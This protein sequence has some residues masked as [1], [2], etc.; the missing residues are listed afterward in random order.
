VAQTT[1]AAYGQFSTNADT[2]KQVATS[3]SQSGTEDAVREYFKDIPV[4]AE[5][6]RCESS[7]RQTLADGSI[8]RG[9][10]DS[11]DIGVMQI[12]TFYHGAEAA[13][14]G[15]DLTKFEDNMAFA[16]VLYEREGTKPWRASAPC[17]S[18]SLASL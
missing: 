9:K 13:K 5:V 17:W 6:A 16:R 11:R 8:L 1:D 14:L 18:R 15:L 2:V 7:F 4:L 3:T 10:V 12:N